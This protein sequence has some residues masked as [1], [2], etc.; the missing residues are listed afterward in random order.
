MRP[1]HGERDRDSLPPVMQ[2]PT[3]RAM[4]ATDLPKL[5]DLFESSF[6]YRRDEAY[7]VWRFLETPCGPA[8]TI[9]A[10][11]GDRLAGSYTVSP[12]RLD[13]GGERVQGAQS[14]DTMTHPDYRGRGLFTRLASACF[15]RL[16]RDGYEVL[17][18]F[19]NEAS[20]PGFIRRLQWDH[21]SDIS[22][23]ARPITPLE[24]KPAPLPMLSRLAT[25][26]VFRAPRNGQDVRLARPPDAV[27]NALITAHTAS[28]DL[29]R[30]ARDAT[31]Y[32]WRYAPPARR[33]YQWLTAYHGNDPSGF[34]VIGFETERAWGGEAQLCELVGSEASQVALIRVA[35]RLCY[36]VH[37][38]ALRT[39]TNDPDAIR[40]L[41]ANG[42]VRRGSI[43]LIVKAL[44]SRQLKANVHSSEAWRIFGGDI[45]VF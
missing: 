29:C 2:E 39:L 18:G 40:A 8:P 13:I 9:V 33:S 41:R 26:V 28:K 27:L 34:A 36:D 45:D 3:L 10:E 32:G 24:G 15:D 25:S 4:V 6:G 21:V 12:T 22:Y 44:S 5:R 35:V 43:P 38:K 23:W 16:T 42:F 37:R 14:L 31:Y 7:D 30:I 1:C 19:P 11:D 20:Y 17:Y